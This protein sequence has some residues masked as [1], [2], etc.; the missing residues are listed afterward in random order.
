MLIS[1]SG[2][3]MWDTDKKMDFHTF[4]KNL[5]N[6][7]MHNYW[8][9]EYT[10]YERSMRSKKRKSL[11]EIHAP[12]LYTRQH[13]GRKW[14]CTAKVK[15]QQYVCRGTNF[16]KPDRAICRCN[17]GNWLCTSCHLLHVVVSMRGPES[18]H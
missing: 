5:N 8:T 10:Q 9:D 14:L 3:F 16:K 18:G 6:G 7:L 1:L 17:P 2:I 15:Y 13:N 11:H 12:P 4:R